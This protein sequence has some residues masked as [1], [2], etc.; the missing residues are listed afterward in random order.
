MYLGELYSYTI[1][2]KFEG[3]YYITISV[4]IQSIFVDEIVTRTGNKTQ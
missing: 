2:T 1:I 4:K 3:F